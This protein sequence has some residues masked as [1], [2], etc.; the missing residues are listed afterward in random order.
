MQTLQRRS[1]NIIMETLQIGGLP[2][3][4]GGEHGEEFVERHSVETGQRV[5]I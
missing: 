2:I 4:K 5:M 3:F 1:F